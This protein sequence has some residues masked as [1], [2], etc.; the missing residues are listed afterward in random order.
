MKG[1]SNLLATLRGVRHLEWIALA[2]A[3]ALVLMLMLNSAQER[4]AP[5]S[6]ETGRIEAVLSSVLGAGKVKVLLKEAGDQ[7]A[8]SQG[9]SG[10]KP[11]GVVVV[12]EG[13]GDI[14]VALELQR[15]VRA[16]LGIELE[17]I[18]VLRMEGG[19]GK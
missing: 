18:E 2:A 16:L 11:E 8:F 15:A 3:V 1:F 4:E 6:D 12:A 9:A 19:N 17:R 13:A 14:R 10:A 7:A 5:A